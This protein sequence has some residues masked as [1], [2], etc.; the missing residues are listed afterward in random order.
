MKKILAIA[1]V[2]ALTAGVSA[3]A[4]NPFSDVSPDD[5]AY[6]AVSD[7]SDQGV[8]EGYP[9]G[10]FKG[11]RNMT[12]YELA[13]VIARLMAR[14]DQL[15]AEQKATLDKLA[16]EYADELANL[17]VRVSN[18]E[19][20]VGNISWFGDARMRWKEKGY[21]TDGS[22]KADGW[23]GRMR[24]NAKAQVNDSTYV[25]GRF[26][27]NMN[28][29]DDADANTK[30]DVLFVHHQFGDKVGMNLGRNFLTLGQTGMYYD[31]FFDGAQLFIGDS[32]LTLE[33]GYGRMNTWINDYGQ[34]KDDTVYARLYGQTGRIGYDAEY[35]K[36]VGAADADKKSIWGAG[37][38]VGVT[39]AVDIFGDFYKNTEPKGDPQMW[40]AG[41][42]F[43]HYN[44]KKP[45]TF[46][47]AAQYVRNEAG[48]Y[49]GG[50]TYTAFPASSLLN[51]D[52]KFWLAN[53]DVVLAKNIRLHGE[54]AFNVKTDDSVDYDDLA[55]V[56]L[57]YN[58]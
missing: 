16:G 18:L 45:G 14:E 44:L 36:T 24:I 4:A 17:G 28:F 34:K 50:S 31:D 27:S 57:N 6:Q 12:R 40:T 7:L 13:Q 21:N 37:L 5:W 35:I 32:K 49:F 52:S 39:D 43:G 48:A 47:V 38:T 46:R 15:N 20:K 33:A 29:K 58:F 8:V 19:K 30:M 10:T 25:R 42:G 22:R 23:D 56:S 41:L 54:Y 55:T 11:E 53:A 51:V 3:Y 26:T 2:A 9:D 1:A